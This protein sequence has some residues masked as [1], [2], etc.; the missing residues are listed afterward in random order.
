MPTAWK[1]QSD[2][3]LARITTLA[4][5]P[6]LRYRSGCLIVVRDSDT[7]MRRLPSSYVVASLL[8]LGLVVWLLLGDFQRFQPTP[9]E[10]PP[11][12]AEGSRVEVTTRHSTFYVPR[13]IVQGQLSAEREV[14][15]RANV[16]GVVQEKPVA[17]GSRVNA[18]DTLLI[19]DNDALPERLQQARDELTLAQAEYA[20][21]QNLRQRELISQPEL[22]RLQASLSASAAQVAQLEKQLNDSRPQAPFA[23]TLGRVQVEV[24]D[25]VQPGEEWGELV[26]DSRLTGEAWVSQQEVGELSAGLPVSARLLNGEQL[27]GELTFVSPRADE[28]TRTFYVE[29]TLDNPRG[30]TM[31]GGSAELTITLAPREVHR[32]SPALLSLN[33]E[34]RLA[35]KYVDA[36]NDVVQAP[37][38]LVSATIE[39]AYV[40]GLPEQIELITLGAGLVEP[41]ERVDPVRVDDTP[42]E[43]R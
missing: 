4:Q 27:E 11:P 37:V 39:S 29:A 15:L 2:V 42:R 22:L 17:Q 21:A 28:S 9:P 10:S 24:G 40:S 38:E 5:A 33:D 20:G 12:S 36:A 8:V 41:G 25:L 6:P 43:A 23:G 7:F 31:A 1:T 35:V 26:D 16:G 18:G 30:L 32:L 19:L 13:Q 14:T 34:G 3:R